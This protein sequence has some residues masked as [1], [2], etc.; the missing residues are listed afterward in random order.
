[1]SNPKP[2]K[3]KQTKIYLTLTLTFTNPN[4]IPNRIIHIHRPPKPHLWYLYNGPNDDRKLI[5]TKVQPTLLSN[6]FIHP[7]P[8]DPTPL[9]NAVIKRLYP[10]HI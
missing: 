1:M 4:R 3:Q 9:S 10:T 7:Q 2:N 8:V 5:Q 6:P